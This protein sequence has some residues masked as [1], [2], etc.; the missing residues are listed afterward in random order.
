MLDVRGT[1]KRRGWPSPGGGSGPASSA[2]THSSNYLPSLSLVTLAELLGTQVERRPGK[3]PSSAVECH[4]DVGSVDITVGGVRNEF[5]FDAVLDESTT[6]ED[7]FE[8]SG[9]EPL[10]EVRCHCLSVLCVGGLNI[11]DWYHPVGNGRVQLHRIRVWPDRFRQ[12]AHCY[13]TGCWS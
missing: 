8:L 11:Y 3:G 6:Q 10:V 5:S 1:A 4:P 13:W 12:D 2:S 9:V 7:V